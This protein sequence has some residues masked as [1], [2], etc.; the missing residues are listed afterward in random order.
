MVLIG[1]IGGAAVWSRA[2]RDNIKKN[3]F[4]QEGIFK[5]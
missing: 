1:G 3:A 2:I 5:I 4:R